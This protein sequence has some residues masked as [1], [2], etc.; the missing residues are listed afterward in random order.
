MLI[1]HDFKTEMWHF[2]KFTYCEELINI[3]LTVYMHGKLASSDK[4]SSL[5]THPCIHKNNCN[6]LLI[7]TDLGLLQYLQ[8][9]VWIFMCF[10]ILFYPLCERF[11]MNTIV[12][13]VGY[14]SKKSHNILFSF[15]NL[16]QPTIHNITHENYKFY[17]L[18]TSYN[19]PPP[20]NL[21][22]NISLI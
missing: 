10:F 18:T 7:C 11:S 13:N 17:I 21:K 16:E 3:K 19:P 8:Q 9:G 4:L 1:L 15:R 22:G 14:S 20:S 5:F 12:I 6:I 2:Y